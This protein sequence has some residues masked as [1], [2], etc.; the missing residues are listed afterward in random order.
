MS[1]A[2]GNLY[3]ESIGDQCTEIRITVNYDNDPSPS[4]SLVL[5]ASTTLSLIPTGGAGVTLSTSASGAPSATSGSTSN[6][7]ALSV[8]YSSSASHASASAS[9]GS[10][11]GSASG[12]ATGSASGSS[13]ATASGAAP[14]ASGNAAVV[15]FPALQMAFVGALLAVFGAA[16]AL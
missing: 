1:G 16:S 11:G 13:S 7:T 5:P 8:S 14:P 4:S 9:T 12:S 10:A 3:D 15:S 2:F 6:S